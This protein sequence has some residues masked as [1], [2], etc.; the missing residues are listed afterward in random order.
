MQPPYAQQTKPKYVNDLKRLNTTMK[1]CSLLR[2]KKK[3]STPLDYNFETNTLNDEGRQIYW[4]I[5]DLTAKCGVLFS[6][7]M[8]KSLLILHNISSIHARASSKL[9]CPEESCWIFLFK[10]QPTNDFSERR[11]GSP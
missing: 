10:K 8:R 4:S 5:Q 3:S 6:R 7:I 9:S 2:L 11:Y 1:M